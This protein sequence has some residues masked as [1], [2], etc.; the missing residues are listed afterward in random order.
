MTRKLPRIF[1]TSSNISMYKLI[2]IGLFYL[3][4]T[5]L[6]SC[7][8]RERDLQTSTIS[9]EKVV[10]SL[11][12]IYNII[13]SDSG[14]Y[15]VYSGPEF[16]RSKPKIEQ[17]VAHRLSNAISKSVGEELKKL[18]QEKKYVKV[19]LENIS[20]STKDMDGL[21]DVVYEVNI[22]FIEVPNACDAFTAFDHRGGWGHSK[23]ERGVRKEFAKEKDVRII[24]KS[25]EEGLQEFW[26][27]YK[28]KDYL[29]D[30]L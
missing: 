15:G 20:M 18:Y 28:H 21:D 11:S 7:F 16:D 14:C 13:C 19:D 3:L 30:C 8:S 2:R 4:M 6:V 1:E 22:P 24:E 9:V 26:L 27:Q 29:I 10:D 25:T 5:S 12:P 17:D 23:K